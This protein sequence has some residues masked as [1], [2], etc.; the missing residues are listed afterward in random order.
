M[1]NCTSGFCGDKFANTD[2]RICSVIHY[3]RNWSISVYSFGFS[4]HFPYQPQYCGQWAIIRNLVNWEMSVSWNN[5]VQGGWFIR[6]DWVEWGKFFSGIWY[7]LGF[8]FQGV[9]TQPR[10]SILIFFCLFLASK[11]SGFPEFHGSNTELL[12]IYI[13][14]DDWSLEILAHRVQ[15]LECC[16]KQGFDFHRFVP[17]SSDKLFVHFSP[18]TLFLRAVFLPIA[19]VWGVALTCQPGSIE[20]FRN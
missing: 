13:H 9:T 14:K 3:L 8:F 4:V 18:L 19:I 16:L 12:K 17:E 15:A 5:N 2:T 10:P 1:K 6:H 7:R 11:R 20:I